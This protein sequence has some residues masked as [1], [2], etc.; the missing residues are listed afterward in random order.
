MKK[1]SE[2]LFSK[3]NI[4]VEKSDSIYL[5]GRKLKKLVIFYREYKFVFSFR[6]NELRKINMDTTLNVDV[7]ISEIKA[8]A[9]RVKSNRRVKLK[10]NK[11][12]NLIYDPNEEAIQLEENNRIIRFY[13][14]YDDDQKNEFIDFLEQYI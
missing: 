9:E 10:L 3:K 13:N 6:S 11:Y 4:N 12:Q 8:F 2:A 1:L 5:C 7:V 14:F